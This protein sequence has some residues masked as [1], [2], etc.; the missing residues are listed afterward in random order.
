[1]LRALCFFFL[2]FFFHCNTCFFA[3]SNEGKRKSIWAAEFV[4]VLVMLDEKQTQLAFELLP[5]FQKTNSLLKKKI[6]F[7]S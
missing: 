6:S 4:F 3:I 7:V 1:M 5:S 2:P